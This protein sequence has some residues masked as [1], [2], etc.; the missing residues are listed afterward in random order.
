MNVILF[1][2]SETAKPLSRQDPR[3]RHILDVLRFGPGD[4]LDV[5]LI[6][7]PMGKATILSVNENVLELAF[8]F[9]DS[10][11]TLHPV[12]III[13]LPRPP[14][15][16][17]ILKDLTTLGAGALHF[18]STDRGEKSYLESRLWSEGEFERLLK[19][20]AQQAFSTCLPEVT[21]HASLAA[22]L[23]TL[24]RATDR[25]ALDNYEATLSLRDYQP[26]HDHCT[27]AVGSER[28]W[29]SAE[30]DL[31]RERD[32]QLTSMGERVL[33]TETACI[34]GLAIVLAKLPGV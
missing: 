21:L 34:A 13:G 15:C 31:L 17:R 12:T 4:T 10:T 22:C 27:L 25:L 32:F 5:G 8:Q 28:G 19:E 24:T 16:R 23:E 33:K 2:T 14:S 29:S 6:S 26:R 11:E 3:A 1:T 30:R 20:G 7:G 18:V 9:A